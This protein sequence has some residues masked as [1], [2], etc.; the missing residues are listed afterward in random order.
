MLKSSGSQQ[1]IF[2]NPRKKSE[3]S[4]KIQKKNPEK[5]EKSPK[6]PEKF[7]ILKQKKSQ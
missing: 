4:P 2:V 5:S 1:K 3:K 7:K 6:I